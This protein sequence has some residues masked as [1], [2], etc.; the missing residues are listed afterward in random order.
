MNSDFIYRHK[1]YTYM[2]YVID[3]QVWPYKFSPEKDPNNAVWPQILLRHI[4]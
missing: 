3:L 2:R 1:L 4:S